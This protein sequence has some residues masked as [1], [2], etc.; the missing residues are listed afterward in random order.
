MAARNVRQSPSKGPAGKTVARAGVT[1]SARAERAPTGSGTGRYRPLPTGTHGLDPELVKLDQRERLQRALIEL[2]ADKGYR[3]VRIVDLTKLAHVSQPT[4][5]TLYADKEEL[6][7]S[8]YDEIAQ[9]TGRAIMSAYVGEGPH[10]QR[11]VAAMSAWGELAAS[12]PQAISL[13][14][15]GAFGA[16]PQA[17]QRRSAILAGLERRIHAGRSSLAHRSSS[18]SRSPHESRS[19]PERQSSPASQSSP[20]QGEAGTS[21]GDLTVKAI[22]GGIREVTA[23]RLREGRA[24]ELPALAEELTT[25]ASCYPRQLPAG[26]EAPLV[27]RGRAGAIPPPSQ[28]ARRAEG[29]LP[30]GRSDL[31]RQFIVK[32]QR[33][34]IVDATAA[35][36]AEKGLAALTVPEIARRANVSHQTFY[37]I[38]SSKH[39]AFLGA[40]KV[41]MH[42]ALV[43]AVDAY[44]AQLEDWPR[45][46]NAGITALVEFLASEPAH[47]HLSLV[48]TFAACPEAL[49]I[50]GG[51]LQ[52]F[53]SYFDPAYE[54]AAGR[55]Q[56]PAIAGEA[57][58]GGIWQIL[59]HYIESASITEL[60]GAIPQL[61][62]F[63]LTPFI[64]PQAA[65]AYSL[66]TSA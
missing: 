43:I 64:G 55:A 9:R 15:L 45:A 38:Y 3:A 13:L 59:H 47:A 5:Y 58:A 48:D 39:E 63:A 41:G 49:E 20:E 52:A 11:M 26:L 8:V 30:S 14:V 31:P 17:L 19:S 22:L 6:F 62:Y 44:Q 50:R 2:I 53:A 16:G 24:E 61:T 57:I 56:V 4:F 34:R 60:P 1:A 40:Q 23:A 46:I 66:P 29:R 28:R 12:E 18:E 65:L 51:T 10:E 36:V 37:D 42:Q 7:L 21:H 25:W 54:L 33:E 32:S 27:T 35:I